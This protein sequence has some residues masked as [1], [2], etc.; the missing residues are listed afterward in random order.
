MLTAM[1]Y[2]P[3]AIAFVL[4][5]IACDA[6]DAHPGVRSHR[7]HIRGKVHEHKQSEESNSC[8]AL[9]NRG[10]HSTVSVDVGTPP[11]K[12]DIVADTGSDA[13]IV[14]SCGC[15]AS[16]ACIEE[17]TAQCFK[18]KGKSS[19]STYEAA[20]FASP[21][22]PALL[23]MEFGSGMITTEV[24]SDVVTVGGVKVKM[25]DGLLLMV[26]KQLDFSGPF[27]GIL[28]LGIPQQ[29]STPSFFQAGHMSNRSSAR[30]SVW[31][32]SSG[33]DYEPPEFL[34][35][36]KVSQFSLCL[37]GATEGVLRF[38]NQPTGRRLGSVGKLHWGV[39]LNGISVGPVHGG[40]KQL[41][42]VPDVCSSDSMHDGQITPCGAIPDSGTTLLMGPSQQITLLFGT[43]CDNWSR[44]K[45]KADATMEA[46][47]DVFVDVLTQCDDWLSDSVGLSELPALHFH[48]SGSEEDEKEM[49]TIGPWSYI[50]QTEH[51][52]DFN[53]V[54]RHLEGVIGDKVRDPM[55]RGKRVCSPAFGA[56]EMPTSVNGDVWIFGTSF[57]YE[58]N[59]HYDLGS[60]PPSVSFGTEPCGSC[61]N[62]AAFY[63]E[64]RNAYDLA[65]RQPRSVSGPMR[66]P[67]IDSTSLF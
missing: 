21:K 45:T 51:A 5:M 50:V 2:S 62:E 60:D 34:P 66:V 67:T 58:F 25:N 19:S 54:T 22:H 17:E 14:A 35:M 13:I 53:F 46:K 41:V 23:T 11:R 63:S 6:V 59:I 56:M 29:R 33:E 61:D 3:V 39:G 47:A 4:A 1:V 43:L 48:V 32:T 8:T 30:S 64:T 18:T 52:A 28:G 16:G 10:T 9:W 40:S 7:P 26:D 37:S 24:V 36:A 55:A 20:S 27:E 12:F 65:R 15:V 49:L 31:R 42:H 57:F 44:C 38:G